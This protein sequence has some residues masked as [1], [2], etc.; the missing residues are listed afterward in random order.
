MICFR[1]FS[2]PFG[3]GDAIWQK[4]GAIIQQTIQFPASG[5]APMANPMNQADDVSLPNVGMTI[6]S[7][8]ARGARFAICENATRF[9]SGQ[10][11]AATSASAQEVFDELVANAIPGGR[12]V[13]AG[14]IAATRSQ[15]YGYS[16][17]YA[18]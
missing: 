4:Y 10:L 14:V 9:F 18:G 7:V 13:S 3:Y 1:H 8:S 15:E 12:F 2:T 6:D 11:A 17:L 16:L 5:A